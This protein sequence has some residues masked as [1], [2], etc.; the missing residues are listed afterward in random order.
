MSTSSAAGV[1]YGAMWWFAVVGWMAIIFVFSS[2]PDSDLTHRQGIPIGI[3]KFAHLLVFGV[4]GF[5]VAGA[6]RHVDMPRSS[7]W[8]WVTVVLYAMSD[9]IHQAFVPGRSPLVMDVVIDSLG[10][11]VGI[12]AFGLPERLRVRGV[13]QSARVPTPRPKKSAEEKK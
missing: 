11:I 8:A 9:E 2:Q 1:R 13:R 5:L 12:L 7:L 4:L 10:G 6:I 3:Y